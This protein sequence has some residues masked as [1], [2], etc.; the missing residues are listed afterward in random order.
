MQKS[1][2]FMRVE[3]KEGQT[4]R[5]IRGTCFFVLLKEP[6]VG[7]SRGFVYLV[8]NRHLAQPRAKT[9]GT[10]VTVTKTTI[11]LNLVEAVGGRTATELTL[12][13]GDGTRWYFPED[14]SADVAVTPIKLDTHTYDV[15]FMPADRFITREMLK[16]KGI[17][18]GAEVRFAGF[19]YQFPGDARVRPIVREGILALLPEEK[20]V[21]TMDRPGIVYLADIH[22]FAGNSGSPVFVNMVGL[23]GSNIKV[24]GF[25]YGLLGILSGYFFEDADFKLRVATT[26]EGV[27]RAN[28]G[29]ST[30]VPIEH[31]QNIL[32][33]P[34]LTLQREIVV[35]RELATRR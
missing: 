5:E 6:R 31:V 34:E 8:T 18:E 26:L 12:F 23:R 27:V 20:L 24:G 9:P 21:T 28:S 19:F 22:A 10:P 17:V 25:P 14:E 29:I 3:Y 7:P 15:I 30:I 16:T 35:Q 4:Q 33:S 32:D 13:Q 2:A 1:V 11:T